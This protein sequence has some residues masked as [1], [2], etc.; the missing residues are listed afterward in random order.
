MGNSVTE[1]GP[2]SLGSIIEFP[3]LYI[4]GPSGG[5]TIPVECGSVRVA[6]AC[7]VAVTLLTVANAN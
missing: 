2:F 3:G 7:S 5:D 1:R 6:L 4:T